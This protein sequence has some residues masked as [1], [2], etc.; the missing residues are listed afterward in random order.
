MYFLQPTAGK[1]MG[2]SFLQP[3]GT[4]ICQQPAWAGNQFSPSASQKER[5]PANTL[6]SA[7]QVLEQRNQPRTGSYG[8]VR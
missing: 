7:F 3:H 4:K 1:E 2:V 5:R 6:I 8:I